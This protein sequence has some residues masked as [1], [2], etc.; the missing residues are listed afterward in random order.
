MRERIEK[1]NAQ[2]MHQ[3]NKHKREAHFQPGDLVWIHLRK[4]RFLSE[5]K[6]KIMPRSDGPFEILE[7]VGPNAYKVDL[8][9]EYGVSATFNVADLSPYFE[10]NEGIPSLRSN[11]NP[12]GEDD[13]DHLTR[14][15]TTMANGPSPAKESKESKKF[16]P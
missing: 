15:S 7:K 10:E 6:S 14:P 1:S 3:A 4:E 5:R 11:S 2:A 8:P 16:M 12:P 9:G 13:G